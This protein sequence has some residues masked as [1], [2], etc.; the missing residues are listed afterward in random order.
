M[1]VIAI[2]YGDRI[3]LCSDDSIVPI[4]TMFD[5]C[6]NEIDDIDFAVTAVV[7]LPNGLFEVIEFS[8]FEPVVPS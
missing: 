1:N 2:H 7:E 6:E 5:H 3:A 4:G 8:D